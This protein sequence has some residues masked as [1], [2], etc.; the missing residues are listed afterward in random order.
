MTRSV[1]VIGAAGAGKS[2]FTAELLERLYVDLGPLEDL[3]GKP[4][5]AGN[6]VTLRGHRM[7]EKGDIQRGYIGIYLG[8]MRD[9]FPGSDGLDR[10]SSPT[11]EEWLSMNERRHLPNVI[12]AEG[13][14]LA[15][16]RF[17]YALN[18]HT[19]LLVLA[20]RCD[21]VVHDLRLLARG[22][23]QV[24]SFVQSTVTKTENLV[25]DLTAAGA[26]VRW[27][28]SDDPG[29]WEDALHS[30]ESHLAG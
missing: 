1:Y 20:L 6:T 4:N 14:T 27:V 22:A 26:T 19:D 16:R 23:G 10:A 18:E 7:Y 21:P 25:R 5:A 17:M 9:Q 2:T 8:V 13:A 11:G 24:T 15:T 28:E 30:A 29:D 3:H 12:L